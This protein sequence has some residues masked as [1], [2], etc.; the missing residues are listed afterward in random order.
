MYLISRCVVVVR[1]KEKFLSWLNQ[2]PDDDTFELTLSQIRSDCTSFLV[3]EYD[4]P[5]EVVRWVDE[6]YQ[7]IFEMELGSWYEHREWW[8]KDR[9]LK[10]F[11]EWFDVEIHTTVIDTVND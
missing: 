4:E 1:P 2:V 3:E 5:E 9:S 8:P 11:W 7:R 6:H 10:T